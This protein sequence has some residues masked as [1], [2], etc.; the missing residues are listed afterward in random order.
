MRGFWK[1]GGVYWWTAT[2]NGLRYRESTETSDWREASRIK[3]TRIAELRKAPADPL[4]RRASFGKLT[5]AAAVESYAAERRSQVSPRMVQYWKENGRRLTEFFAD[6]KLAT[7][8]DEQMAAY[9]N[10]RRDAGIAPRTVNGELS[11]LR[12]LLRHARLWYRLSE[13]YHPLKNTKAP[14]GVALNDEALERL[15]KTVASRPEWLHAYVAFVL[16]FF[17]G[18]RSCEIKGLRWK[19][20]NFEKRELDIHRS[21]TPAGWRTPSL[22]P[23]C[24]LALSDLRSRAAAVGLAETEHFVLPW[25]GRDKRIDPTRPMTSWR[26]AWRSARKAAQLP[27]LRFHD[28]RHT[29]LTVLGEKGLPDEVIRAQMGH[30]SRDMMKTYSHARRK[31]LNEAAR[32]LEPRFSLPSATGGAGPQ[33]G[34]LS[35]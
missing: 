4:R 31:A 35:Q 30:V 5:V 20:V 18:L 16:A 17:C 11:V 15:A 22:N 24:L 25:H 33:S 1:R 6:T 13:D 21:K 2:V 9:Q 3:N 32:A 19:D 26:T 23:A 14:V 29:A 27:G 7:V 8:S 10:H 28:G 12:Q 34:V